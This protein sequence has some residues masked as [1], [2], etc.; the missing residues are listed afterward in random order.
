MAASGR[1]SDSRICAADVEAFGSA[2]DAWFWTCGALMARHEGTR[3]DGS[4]LKRPC[5]P[6]DVILCVTRLLHNGRIA[7]RHARVLGLWGEQGLRPCGRHGGGED[8]KSW[9]E[10]MSILNVALREKGIVNK[11]GS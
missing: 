9:F 6:D 7:A 10:A 2:E 8:Q 5:D 3:G 4:P 11:P 1:T